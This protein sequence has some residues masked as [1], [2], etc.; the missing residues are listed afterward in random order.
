MMLTRL[1]EEEYMLSRLRVTSTDKAYSFLVLLDLAVR[2]RS[3]LFLGYLIIDG[4]AKAW[5]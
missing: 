4:A 2:I 3:Y 5:H 1:D